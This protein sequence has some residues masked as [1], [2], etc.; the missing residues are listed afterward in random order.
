MS[1]RI[2]QYVDPTV[3]DPGDDTRWIAA[4]TPEAAQVYARTHGW[5]LVNNVSLD[6]GPDE[7]LHRSSH[8]CRTTAE[9]KR[10]GCDV[11]L[12]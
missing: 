4:S 6:K 12:E 8:Y 9:L 7:I 5:L 3:K 11:V 1:K 10:A 2:Y